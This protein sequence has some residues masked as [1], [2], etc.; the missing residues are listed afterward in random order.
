MGNG[1]DAQKPK[2][3]S[4]EGEMHEVVIS[5][6]FYKWEEIGQTLEGYLMTEEI[7]EIQSNQ[8]GGP[9]EIPKFTILG[10]DDRLYGVLG[11]AMLTRALRRV[12]IGT[13]VKIKLVD[14][15]KARVGMMHMLQ[16]TAFTTDP[17]ALREAMA[18]QTAARTLVD[19][20][21]KALNT[22]EGDDEGRVYEPVGV[23]KE[24]GEIVD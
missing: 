8:A 1:K 23:V 18:T 22:A 2:T 3:G 4:P 10:T 20:Q 19:R 11:T 13:H 15:V 7:A 24:T 17:H 21:M 6:E 9:T 14:K 12:R 5:D 16:V